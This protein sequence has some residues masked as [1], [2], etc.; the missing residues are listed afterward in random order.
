MALQNVRMHNQIYSAAMVLKF[1]AGMLI[2]KMSKYFS[3]RKRIA[4]VEVVMTVL[5]TGKAMLH[6]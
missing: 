5:R 3:L 1:H 4:I 6:S 2:R